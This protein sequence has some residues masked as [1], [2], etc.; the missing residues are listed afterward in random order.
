LGETLISGTS[1]VSYMISS[2]GNTLNALYAD[3]A[4]GSSSYLRI[5][6]QNWTPAI[7]NS[8]VSSTLVRAQAAVPTPSSLT[9]LIGMGLMGLVAVRRRR[10]K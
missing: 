4:D 8:G 3:Y 1:H 7:S 5:N 2:D 6:S 10:K 9:A